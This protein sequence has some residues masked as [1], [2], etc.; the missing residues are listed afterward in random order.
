M[1]AHPRARISI[2]RWRGRAG[3][4]GLV[5]VTVL[6]LRAG[7]PPFDAVARGLAGGIAAQ[8]VAWAAGVVMWRKLVLAELTAHRD[9]RVAALEARRAAAAGDAMTTA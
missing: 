8:F 1:I 4:A 7:V 6:A 2:R 5:L 3:M 9:A